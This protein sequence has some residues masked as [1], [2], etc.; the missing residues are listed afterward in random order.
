MS[1]LALTASLKSIDESAADPLLQAK[2]RGLMIGYDLRW[3]DQQYNVLGIEEYVEAPLVNVDTAR[4][5]RTFRL[6]GKIDKRITDEN[7]RLAFVDHKTTSESIEDPQAGYW[8]QLMVESQPQHYMLIEWLRGNK[9]DYAIWDV[10][11]RPSISPRKLTKAERNDVVARGYWF[12]GEVQPPPED[13]ET[14]EMYTARLAHD[15]SVERPFAYFQRRMVARHDEQ[16]FD[17]AR[18]LWMHAEEIRTAQAEQRHPRNS[19]AC[20]L[21]GTP[22]KFLGICSGYDSPDSDNWKRKAQTHNELPVLDPD[23]E[24]LTNSRIRTFQT[25][26]KKHEFEYLVRIERVDAEE[27][28]VIAFGSLMHQALDAWW[29]AQRKENNGNS[30]IT[31]PVAGIGTAAEPVGCQQ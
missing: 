14:L 19:G 5:S 18:E 31:S 10:I 28:E 8:R 4:S 6:A 7:M 22:C 24:L 9:V 25:C 20:L 23:A 13:R 21:Y 30:N 16:I 27:R 26:R 11:R 1:S 2:A 29:G 15:C 12:G 17:Y 3:R